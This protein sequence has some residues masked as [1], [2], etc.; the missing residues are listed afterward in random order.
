MILNKTLKGKA[1]EYSILYSLR[2]SQRDKKW[3]DGVL[4]FYEHNKRVIVLNENDMMIASDYFPSKTVTQVIESILLEGKIFKLA[5]NSLVVQILSKE[6]VIYPSMDIV[7]V[8]NTMGISFQE[9]SSSHKD[10]ITGLVPQ[11]QKDS[12]ACVKQEPQATLY[13]LPGA[14]QMSKHESSLQFDSYNVQLNQNNLSNFD[15]ILV[16]RIRK[17]ES[18]LGLPLDDS[19]SCYMPKTT[20]LS[21]KLPHS[22]LLKS[23]SLPNCPR[24][25]PKS[26]NWFKYVNT[27]NETKD[28]SPHMLELDTDLIP[29]YKVAKKISLTDDIYDQS[30]SKRA[31]EVI[32]REITVNPDPFSFLP[33]TNLDDAEIVYDL[34]EYEQD[35]Q[36]YLLLRSKNENV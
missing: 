6:K 11:K 4:R 34:S 36:F 25:Y 5:T 20:S 14:T 8:E 12:N 29:C 1:H 22:T 30:Q 17:M 9:L 26:S 33:T 7:K 35:E 28:A 31:Q 3:V 32:S 18:Q 27:F 16:K 21:G 15:E 10:N 19:V 24:I 2:V 13:K 23:K